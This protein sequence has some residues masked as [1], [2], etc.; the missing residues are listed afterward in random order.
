M[1]KTRPWLYVVLPFLYLAVVLGLI[2]FQFSKKSDSFS[3]SLGDLTI[4]GKTS[5]GGQPAELALRGRGL[6]FV[7]D[8]NHAL[9]ADAKDGTIS[10]LRPLSWTWKEGNAVVS[11]QEGIS[12]AFEKSDGNGRS[13]LIH[14]VANDALKKFATLHIPFGPQGGSRLNHTARPSLVEVVREKSRL[15]AS[16]DGALDR[17]EADNTFVLTAGKNGFRPA[18]LDPLPAG[19]SNDLAWLTLEGTVSA[20]DAEALLA[21][22]WNKAY[23]AWS[24]STNFSTR[25]A[26]AWGREGL[27]RSDYANAF[28][29]IQS[30][31]GRD[32]KPWGF[33]AV[34]YLGNLM[35]LTSQQRRAVEAASSRSQPDWAGQGQLW[36]D[37]RRYGPEGSADRVRDLL[38]KGK[39]PDDIAG[40]LAFFQNLKTIQT[41]QPSEALA[42]RLQETAGLLAASVI[43]RD[44]DLFVRSGDGLLDLR[45][46]LILGRLWLDFSHS[47]SNEVYGVAGARLLSSALAFQDP[48]GKLPETLVLQD[49]Q[50]VRQEGAILPEEIY[51]SVKPAPPT[52]VDLDAWGPG[53][54]IKAPSQV[55]SQNITTAQARFVFR[56]PAGSAEHLILSGVPT[57]DHIT[58]H[59]I[60]WRT[61]SQFQS[62]TDGWAYSAS[63]QTLY[64]KIKHRED[65]EEL[66]IHFQADE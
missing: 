29:R 38:L 3:Q 26:D 11:F 45:S 28:S 27:L 12:L 42:A 39:I 63:T 31:L 53:S 8:S 19:V 25:L 64:V 52:E 36:L 60:R 21:Q 56:F 46:S 1:R 65:L 15:L 61:D 13:L 37:A 20:D 62:Y 44:G 14:P 2:A 30:L 6:E 18:R 54:F 50:I 57:F 49:G 33:D 22:Y 43:R 51:S 48:T 4:S 66:V 55:V 35:D 5:T 59:G 47:L 32:S 17:I 41:N 10:R 23:A 34:S 16:V 9:Q 7:F 40:R 24:T 58:L